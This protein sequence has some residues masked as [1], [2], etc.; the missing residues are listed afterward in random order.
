MGRTERPADL[1]EGHMATT[2][3]KVAAVLVMAVAALVLAAAM[4]ANAAPHFFGGAGDTT[5]AAPSVA[6]IDW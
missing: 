2:T 5:S 1:E 3:H 6:D 4:F